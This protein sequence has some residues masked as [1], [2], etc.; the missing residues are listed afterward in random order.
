MRLRFYLDPATSEPHIYRHNVQEDEVE[1]VLS[2]PMED[3]PGRDQSRI[4]LGQTDAGRYLRV[5]YVPDPAPDSV[6]I[7]TAYEPGPKAGNPLAR[8]CA[9]GTEQSVSL[10]RLRVNPVP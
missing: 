7:V 5:I 1:E 10:P 4:A 6:F 3:R 9:G 8:I 2:R